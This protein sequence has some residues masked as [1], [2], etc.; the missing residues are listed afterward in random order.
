MITL[1]IIL[2][3]LFVPPARR[4][5]GALL[6]GLFSVLGLAFLITRNSGGRHKGF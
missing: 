1:T 3:L 5:L 2:L 6:G 4:V